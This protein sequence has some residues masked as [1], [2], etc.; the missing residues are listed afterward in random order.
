MPP[1][2]QAGAGVQSHRARVPSK[3][4]T[5]FEL[6]GGW[7]DTVLSGRHSERTPGEEEEPG[8]GGIQPVED[9]SRDDAPTAVQGAGRAEPTR[10]F[11]TVRARAIATTIESEALVLRYGR[12]EEEGGGCD[13][14]SRPRLFTQ[15]QGG[16]NAGAHEACEDQG[17]REEEVEKEGDAAASEEEV[18]EERG[19]GKV[20]E[21]AA[22]FMIYGT[23]KYAYST[24]QVGG[25][26]AYYYLY[27]E[28]AIIR[29]LITD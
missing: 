15:S 1:H 27:F 16:A 23:F 10:I 26:Y 18:Q 29:S 12:E 8:V 3:P 13:Y 24:P 20:P 14:G 2:T 25:Q 6:A 28:T 7:H 9:E 5:G 4:P 17:Q 19:F 11:G 21:A 22:V